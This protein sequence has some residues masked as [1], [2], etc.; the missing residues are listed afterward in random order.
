MPKRTP[1]EAL[2]SGIKY[3]DDLNAAMKLL[4]KYSKRDNIK[5]VLHLLS[6][7]TKIAKRWRKVARKRMDK[8]ASQWISAVDK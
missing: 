3:G 2:G 8:L 6:E 5:Q 7:E 4:L 1:D